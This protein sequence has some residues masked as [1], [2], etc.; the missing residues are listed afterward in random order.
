MTAAP[1]PEL[2]GVDEYAH[3]LETVHRSSTWPG[4]PH[5]DGTVPGPPIQLELPRAVDAPPLDT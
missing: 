5:P 4:I 3:D 2:P 1:E